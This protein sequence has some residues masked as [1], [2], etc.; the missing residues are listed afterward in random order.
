LDINNSQV[1]EKFRRYGFEYKKHSSNASYLTFTYRSGFFH[2]AEVVQVSESVSDEKDILKKIEELESLGVSIKRNKY[3]NISQIGDGLFS[4]FF[5]VK[6]WRSRIQEEYQEYSESV[7]KSF[8]ESEKLEYRYIDAPFSINGDE[9]DTEASIVS[10]VIDDIKGS[11]SKLILVEAPAGFGKTSTSYELINQLSLDPNLPIPFFTEFSRDRQARVFSHVFVREVDRAFSQVKSPVVIDELQNGR[12]VIVLDGFDELLSDD[13]TENAG[14]DY[15]NAEPMLETIGELLERNAKVVITSRR[16]AV[17]DGSVFNEWVDRFS[18]K[19]SFK[20]YRI[21]SPRIEDWLE[22]PRRSLL[23]AELG[24]ELGKLSNPVL[25]SY[26]RALTDDDF[27]ALAGKPEKIVSHYFFTMLEREMDRQN[28]RMNPSE[29]SIILSKV[30]GDMCE[31]NYTSD[32]RDK[33]VDFLKKNCLGI[34]EDTRRLYSAKDRPTIDSLALTL[35]AHAFFDRSNQGEGKIE[36]VNEFVFGNYIAENILD[37]GTGWMAADERFVEPAI[38]SYA[39]RV[40]T[41][42]KALWENLVSMREFLT[43]SELFFFELKMLDGNLESDFCQKSI[44]SLDIAESSFFKDICVDGIS[45]S[46][47]T[48]SD[49]IFYT[50]NIKNSTFINC[51]FY[52][53]EFEGEVDGSFEFLNCFSNNEFLESIFIEPVLEEVSEYSDITINILR[54]FMPVGS[55]GCERIHIPLSSIYKMA[56]GKYTKRDVTKKIKSLK[57]EGILMDAADSSYIAVNTSRM[58]DMKR[59]LGVAK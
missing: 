40:L 9:A 52:N 45:F 48:F 3:S 58:A 37:L 47:C 13:S 12:I 57:K 31:R 4:G 43:D 17:F 19:F 16:A 33:I 20:R 32:S 23:G 1:I 41:E 55:S 46:N 2:N 8:P 28:L 27:K 15:E 11:D 49:S 54:R 29:Q 39:V 30:A 26:L 7:L 5:D 36:F 14:E 18:S 25:L 42:R 38:S 51:K 10:K 21:R 53:C 24:A 50:S 6:N 56:N 59:I 22:E 34:L 44:Y 35:A